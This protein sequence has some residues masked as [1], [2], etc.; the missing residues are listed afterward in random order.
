M[1]SWPGWVPGSRAFSPW[2]VRLKICTPDLREIFFRGFHFF[3]YVGQNGKWKLYNCEAKG[4][5]TSVVLWSPRQN[6]LYTQ[7]WTDFLVSCLSK[8]HH[9]VYHFNS[10]ICIFRLVVL[11]WNTSVETS[12]SP[13]SRSS[14]WPRGA[15]S[16]GHLGASIFSPTDGYLC[17]GPSIEHL[18][19]NK[20]KAFEKWEK[21]TPNHNS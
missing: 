18:R 7:L 15:G 3:A 10:I 17:V 19:C 12:P 1:S 4:S 21:D 11:Q 6:H 16:L 20:V 2:N 13:W 8:D 9:V 14:R 5:R